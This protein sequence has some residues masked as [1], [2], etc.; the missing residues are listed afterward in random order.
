M[1]QPE[2]LIIGFGAVG[3]LY[4]YVLSQAG[5]RVTAVCRSAFA[6]MNAQGI[7]IKSE[8]F[9]TIEHWKPHRLVASAGDAN[10]R[11]YDFII[12]ATKALPDL[13]PTSSIL[14]EFLDSQYSKDTTVVLI[15]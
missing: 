13:L 14:A 7:E 11:A 15:Q 6:G 9:G 2:V 5:C 3:V 1:A 8:K 10:D 4:G 12:C